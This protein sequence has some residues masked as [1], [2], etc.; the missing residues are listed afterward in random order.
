[1]K[2]GNMLVDF[3]KILERNEICL[4]RMQIETLFNNERLKIHRRKTASQNSLTLI[5]CTLTITIFFVESE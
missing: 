4:V 3:G 5:I 1:M 2:N